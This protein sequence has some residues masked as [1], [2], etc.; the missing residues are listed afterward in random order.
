MADL[1]LS[2][3]QSEKIKKN[4]RPTQQFLG[5]GLVFN[6]LENFTLFTN[7][8]NF[9]AQFQSLL[10]IWHVHTP[11]YVRTGKRIKWSNN[12]LACVLSNFPECQDGALIFRKQEINSIRLKIYVTRRH[13]PLPLEITSVQIYLEWCQNCPLLKQCAG[14]VEHDTCNSPQISGGEWEISCRFSPAVWKVIFRTQ[15]KVIYNANAT[16]PPCQVVT[17]SHVITRIIKLVN[18]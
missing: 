11:K 10:S 2:K 18:V 15:S 3:I 14:T 5:A 17:L 6:L 7:E 9:W 8:V 1:L 12:R 13:S 16:L 4:I